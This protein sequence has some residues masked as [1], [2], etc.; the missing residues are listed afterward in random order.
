MEEPKP[1]PV[2]AESKQNKRKSLPQLF[3]PGQSG[4]PKGRPKGVKTL[5]TILR[6]HLSREA[7]KYVKARDGSITYGENIKIDGKA[8]KYQELF[9][10]RIMDK[11]IEKGD[12][13]FAEMI[14]DRMEGKPKQ[15]IEMPKDRDDRFDDIK[16]IVSILSHGADHDTTPEE[17]DS[18]EEDS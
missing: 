10:I 7:R 11:A 5:S 18:V 15:R 3:K 4:N 8:V 1:D 14:F 9:I 12:Y 2:Q 13:K 16:K 17:E 6:E